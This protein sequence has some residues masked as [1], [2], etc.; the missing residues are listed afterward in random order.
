MQDETENYFTLDQQ[1]QMVEVRWVGGQ[2]VHLTV[3]PAL[4]FEQIRTS[5]GNPTGRY[6]AIRDK[7]VAQALADKQSH[8]TFMYGSDFKAD[9]PAEARQT[10]RRI[11]HLSTT[12][13]TMVLD[14]VA[15]SGIPGVERIKDDEYMRLSAMYKQ[16]VAEGRGPE[17]EFQ[18]VSAYLRKLEIINKNK[19]VRPLLQGE[20]G[21]RGGKTLCL[22]EG[23]CRGD[24][25]AVPG[26]AGEE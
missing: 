21:M 12:L 14:R 9:S 1:G 3:D 4:Q 7:R 2:Q 15:P 16:A 25:V 6:C 17:C 26:K 5:E 13:N 22:E 20:V 10:M 8:S 19:V 11:S 23:Y 18:P 24:R